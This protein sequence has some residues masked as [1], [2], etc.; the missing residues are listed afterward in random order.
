MTHFPA[1]LSWL[2]W[3]LLHLVVA[4]TLVMYFVNFNDLI[5]VFDLSMICENIIEGR[6]DWGTLSAIAFVAKCWDAYQ[7]APYVG[8][9]LV[10]TSVSLSPFSVAFV[11]AQRQRR[12]PSPDKK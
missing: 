7:A 10:I 6:V 3:A 5:S 9:A 11:V 4:F 2:L 12:R 8:A 1:W